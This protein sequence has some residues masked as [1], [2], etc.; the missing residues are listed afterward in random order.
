MSGNQEP[1]PICGS[2]GNYIDSGTMCLHLSPLPSPVGIKLPPL[3]GPLRLELP[4]PP[5]L[6]PPMSRRAVPNPQ[7]S[8]PTKSLEGRVK[9]ILDGWNFDVPLVR[10]D[11]AQIAGPKSRAFVSWLPGASIVGYPLQLPT[12]LL[13]LDDITDTL[14]AQL[15]SEFPTLSRADV[16]KVVV[17]AY[18][19]KLDSHEK[20][21]VTLIVSLV[22]SPQQFFWSNQHLPSLWQNGYQASVGLNRRYHLYGWAGFEQSFL[23]QLSGSSL[24]L[25][26]PDWFQNLL[27]VYQ[28]AYV[29][30]LGREFLFLGAPGWWSNVQGSVFAQLAAG[31]GS[32]GERNL[33]LGIMGQAAVGGQIAINIGWL[34]FIVN[35]QV[36]YSWLSPTV[37]PGSRPLSIFG[38]QF[39]IGVGGSWDTPFGQRR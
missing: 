5:V 19:E 31:V 27:A 12:E 16:L 11:R 32:P 37:E 35:D 22:Y 29:A 38:N 8:A 17:Q 24:S 36:V 9:E 30:P 3:I 39:G 20:R 15:R 34:Q 23:L 33:Y 7:P 13:T 25:D 2:Q 4:S 14:Y 6:S 26:S 18:K 10:P 21:P 28:A 1:K